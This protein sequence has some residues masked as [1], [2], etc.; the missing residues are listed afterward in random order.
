[1]RWKSY[2]HIPENNISKM[3][4]KNSLVKLALIC[5][6]FLVAPAMAASCGES[7]LTLISH[8]NG[9]IYFTTDATCPNWCQLAGNPAFIKQSYAMLLTAQASNKKVTF[10]WPKLPT[11]NDKNEVYSIPDFLVTIP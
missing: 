10:A 8:S 9:N 6:A 7:V 3:I 2:N 11:C 1:M 5:N 4:K